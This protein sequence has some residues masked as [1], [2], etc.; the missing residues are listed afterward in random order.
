MVYGLRSG[1]P[2]LDTVDTL[3]NEYDGQGS[4]S[5]GLKRPSSPTKQLPNKNVKSN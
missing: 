4:S 1:R 2:R 3:K 5:S